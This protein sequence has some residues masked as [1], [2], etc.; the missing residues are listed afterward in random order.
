MGTAKILIITSIAEFLV[1]HIEQRVTVAEPAE[2]V[3]EYAHGTLLPVG[4]VIRGMRRQKHIIQP[5]KS[6]PTR[7][8][9]GVEDVQRRAADATLAQG[10]DQHGYSHHRPPANINEHCIRLHYFKFSRPD[11]STRFRR[12]RSYDYHVV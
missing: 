9:F 5:I 12:E 11:R 4:C 2:I 1:Y 10:S 7:Q 8:G 6:M 3:D